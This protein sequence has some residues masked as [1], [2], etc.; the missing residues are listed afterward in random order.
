[1]ATYI[2]WSKYGKAEP[3]ITEECIE[4]TS[5][6]YDCCTGPT[7]SI[8]YDDC[9]TGPTGQYNREEAKQKKEHIISNV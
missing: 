9:P 7:G 3:E 6:H 4:Q 8:G 5:L 1:M 2:D